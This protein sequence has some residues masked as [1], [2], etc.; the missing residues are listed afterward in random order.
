V[1]AAFNNEPKIVIAGEVDGGNNV[2]GA[3]GD[4][5]I[6]TGCR[7]PTTKPARGLRSTSVFPDEIRVPHFPNARGAFRAAWLTTQYFLFQPSFS[8]S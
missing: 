1:A 5:R 2:L 4:D 7:S 6:G 3:P 8:G